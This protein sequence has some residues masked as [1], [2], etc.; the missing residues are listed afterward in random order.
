MTG[1]IFNA[2]IK[3]GGREATQNTTLT[4]YSAK[5]VSFKC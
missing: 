3:R 2:T 4:F 1:L 5:N